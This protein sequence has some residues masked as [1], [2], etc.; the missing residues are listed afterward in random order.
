VTTVT[1]PAGSIV[2]SSFSYTNNDAGIIYGKLNINDSQLDFDDQFYFSYEIQPFLQVACITN[3]AQAKDT[4]NYDIKSIFANDVYYKFTSFTR[5]NIDYTLLKQQQ[6]IVLNR[7]DDISSGLA[8]ELEEF[9][10]SGG[11]VCVIPD[12]KINMNGYNDFAQQTGAPQFSGIDTNRT[13]SEKP[14]FDDVFFRG[15]FEKRPTQLDVPIVRKHYVTSASTRSLT[16]AILKLKNGADLITVTKYKKGKVY[17]IV[18]P[19]VEQAGNLGQ[20]A[21]FVPIMLRMAELSLSSGKPYYTFGKDAGFDIK[22]VSISGDQVFNLK[23]LETKENIV[24]EF[25][26]DGN[27]ISIFFNDNIKSSG[28][29]ELSLDGKTV[30]GTS[31]NYPRN[32]SQLDYYSDTDI[33]EMLKANGYKDFKVYDKPIDESKIDLASIDNTKKYWTACIWIALIFLFSE[34]L[35]L[36]LWKT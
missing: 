33:D 30:A 7:L 32:E 11:S 1:I 18:S 23:G 14:D 5:Q 27:I 20:H 4:I 3:F 28:S 16:T 17:E 22:P 2:D 12:L 36:K 35:L 29:Y 8:Q 13:V 10:A 15:I 26:N 31:L 9:V 25:K 24:P 19:T 21:L 34:S 6:F